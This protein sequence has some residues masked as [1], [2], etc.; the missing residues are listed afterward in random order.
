[1]TNAAGLRAVSADEG[2]R[3]PG[4]SCRN[5][6][7]LS[8]CSRRSLL[9]GRRLAKGESGH[10][11][12]TSTISRGGAS[13]CRWCDPAPNRKDKGGESEGTEKNGMTMSLEESEC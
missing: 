4:R 9:S 5:Q 7:A 3:D 10:R 6:S 2:S 8:L 1:M 13:L 12:A 11:A